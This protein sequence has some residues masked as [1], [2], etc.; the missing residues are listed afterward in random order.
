MA[1]K[2]GLAGSEVLMAAI[3]VFGERGVA[4]T[5]VEDL[6]AA[7]GLARRTFYKQY[8]S[9]EDVLTKLYEHVTQQ[10]VVTVFQAR[11]SARD[12]LSGLR[13]ALDAYLLFHVENHRIVRVLVQEA[14]RSESPLA[15]MRTRFRSSLVQALDEAVALSTGIHLDPYVF[16][17]LISGLEGLSLELLAGEPSKADIERAR[18]VCLGLVQATV[19]AAGD[20]PKAL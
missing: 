8:S 5:R 11:F 10:L 9:K 17:A 6:L 19:S 13:A 1:V 18:A 14:I 15:P 2:D 20:M 7:A 16:L 3:E 12:P 4:D